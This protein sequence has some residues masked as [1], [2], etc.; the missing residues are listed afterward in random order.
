[1]TKILPTLLVP[2]LAAA[3]VSAQSRSVTLEPV[4]DTTL[5]S[6]S[7]STSNGSGSRIFCGATQSTNVRRALLAFD[8]AGSVPPG[9]TIQ[10]VRLELTVARTIAPDLPVALHRLTADWGEAGSVASGGQGGGTAAQP[11]DATWRDAFFPSTPWQAAGGDFVSTASAS[12]VCTATGVCTWSSA[13]MVADVQGFL[14][15]PS[16]AFGWAVVTRESGPPTARAFHSREAAAPFRPRLVIGYAPPAARARSV[17]SGCT[18]GGAQPLTLTASGAPTVPAPGF[19]MSLAGGP[20][21]A[22]QAIDVFL[23]VLASPIPLGQGCSFWGNP[24]TFVAGAVVPGSLALPIPNDP[25]LIGRSL[26]F[27]GIAVDPATSAFATSNALVLE[28]GV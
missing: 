19:S 12:V 2:V 21:G 9:S 24:S 23:D 17:G 20:S 5:Y 22:V 15:S 7:A 28:F 8:V 3:G 25:A 18:G 4:R 11:G 26:A 1:M 27:Q 14:Q 10:S 13:Q 16:T 6:E